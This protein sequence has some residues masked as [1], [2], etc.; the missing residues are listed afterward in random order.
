M[1]NVGSELVK[2]RAFKIKKIRG[3]YLLKKTPFHSGKSNR[4]CNRKVSIGVHD[5][6]ASWTNGVTHKSMIVGLLD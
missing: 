5:E 3:S 6:T 1:A 2:R 4:C